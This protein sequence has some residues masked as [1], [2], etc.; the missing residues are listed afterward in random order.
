MSVWTRVQATVAGASTTYASPV[1]AGNLLVA[2]VGDVAGSIPNVSDSVN[3]V[4]WNLG[5]FS[6]TS[7][8]CGIWWYQPPIGGAGYKVSLSA[9]AFPSFIISEWSNGLITPTVDGTPHIANATS[10]APATAGLTGMVGRDLIICGLATANVSTISAGSGFTSGV[11]NSYV[12]GSHY[13]SAEEYAAN[14]SAGSVSPTFG[15]SASVSWAMVAMAFTYSSSSGGGLF[16]PATL[17]LGAGGP[18]FQ[19]SV[20]C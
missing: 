5:I 7:P 11:I 3:G 16:L 4:N 14:S 1:T 2:I 15:L 10:T 17:S 9:A 13:G 12:A 6:N 19:S 8:Q 20:N 18:F